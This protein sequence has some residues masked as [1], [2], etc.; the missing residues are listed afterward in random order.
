MSVE[1][2]E[3][4]L[5]QQREKQWKFSGHIFTT[6]MEKCREKERVQ[7]YEIWIKSIK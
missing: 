5:I 2:N 7:E 4:P 3:I 6:D 1:L